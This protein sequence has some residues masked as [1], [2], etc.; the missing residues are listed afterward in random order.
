MV[1][2]DLPVRKDYK[3]YQ[4]LEAEQPAQPVPMVLQGRKALPVQLAYPGR[5]G[6]RVQPVPQEQMERPEQ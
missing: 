5:Q 4:D 6:I 2:P 3:E 1:Q